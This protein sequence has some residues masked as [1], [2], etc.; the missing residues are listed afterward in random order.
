M[1]ANHAIRETAYNET[2]T[3]YRL[4]CEG[5]APRKA[6]KVVAKIRNTSE[7][8]GDGNGEP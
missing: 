2:Y 7:R 4:Q 5:L 8:V 6:R 3:V 1:K